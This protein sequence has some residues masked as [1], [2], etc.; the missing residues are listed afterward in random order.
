MSRILG[1]D[2]SVLQ[3]AV[4]ANVAGLAVGRIVHFFQV[5]EKGPHVYAA[6][7]TDVGDDGVAD[8]TVFM[9]GQQGFVW[10][11]PHYA[12]QGDV[13]YKDQHWSWPPRD[14]A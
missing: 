5:D 13:L 9:P 8:L 6:L 3:T 7:V 10:A 11:C 4:K 2:G 1:A 12:G 14:K